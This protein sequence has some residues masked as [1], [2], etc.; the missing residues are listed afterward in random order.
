MI[1][2]AKIFEFE[3]IIFDL[4]GTLC[5]TEPL[6]AQAWTAISKKYGMDPIT[7]ELLSKIGGISTIN[8]CKRFCAQYSLD[9][10]PV[11]MAKEK[12]ANYIENFLPKA[13]PF[14]S[15][16]SILKEAH[17]RGLKTAIATGSQLKE[18]KM[19][20]SIFKIEDYV[21]AIVTSDQVKNGKPAPDTYLE[22]C[23][24]LNGTPSQCLVFEDT[25]IGLQG[26]KAAGMTCLQVTNGEIVSDFIAP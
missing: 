22:A 24:R 20:V 12:T 25:P 17:D 19:L 15:I 26:V 11:Q 6:H 9:V 13:Q 2:K 23:S 7:P 14:E 8:L 16:C 4:D 5:N 18:V 3:Y 1:D 21:D 10:D